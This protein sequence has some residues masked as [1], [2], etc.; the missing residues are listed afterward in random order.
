MYT[1]IINFFSLKFLIFL[2]FIL[3]WASNILSDEIILQKN[4]I[5]ITN[6]DLEKYQRLHKDYF[7]KEI[8]RNT[9]IK[10]LYITFK[11]IDQQKKINPN[12]IEQTDKIIKKDIEDFQLLYSNYILSYF[13]R[14]EILK[15]DFIMMYVNNNNLIK[16]DKLLINKLSIFK[17]NECRNKIKTIKFDSLNIM[18]KQNILNNLSNEVILIADNSYLCLNDTNRDEIN[19]IINNIVSKAGYEEFLKYVYR[20]IK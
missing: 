8:T 18:D 9:A 5:I 15:K 2:I 12:F 14:Y 17:D 13:L 10:N 11:I 4:D 3:F 19:N 6:D 7:G 1:N 20:N 16:L